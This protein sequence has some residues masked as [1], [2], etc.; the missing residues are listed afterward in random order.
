MTES[1]S[2]SDDDLPSTD[3]D[4]VPDQLVVGDQ[5]GVGDFER[6]YVAYA[7]GVRAALRARLANDLDVEDCLN[8]VFEKLWARGR[9]I[10]PASRRA[11]LFVVARNE[12]A[13]WGRKAGRQVR[14]EFVA[15]EGTVQDGAF[16]SGGPTPLESLL[17]QE[18]IASLRRAGC[19]L[20]NDQAEV[21]RYRF[22]EDLSFREIAQRLGIPL[23]TALSRAHSAIKRLRDELNPSEEDA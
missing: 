7:S 5:L 9:A 1:L 20:S 14:G 3:P 8:R 13:L 2:R 12:A 23:G 15:N 17:R 22:F 21:L 11:W 4:E 19:C 10:P 16:R 18:E 6:C